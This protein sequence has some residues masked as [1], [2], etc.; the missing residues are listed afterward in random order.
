MAEA[1]IDDVAEAA[2]ADRS[3]ASRAFLKTEAVRR[4]A[5]ELMLRVPPMG[6]DL[7][8]LRPLRLVQVPIDRCP[9]A[10][11]GLGSIAIE[12]GETPIVGADPGHVVLE[13]PLLVRSCTQKLFS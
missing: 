11:A 13:Q 6:V 9:A 8:T 3:S 7:E 10:V 2:G 5:P 1:S 4:V 12:L